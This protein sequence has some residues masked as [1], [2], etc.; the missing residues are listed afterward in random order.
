MSTSRLKPRLEMSYYGPRTCVE[1]VTPLSLLDE[2][3]HLVHGIDGFFGAVS[4]QRKALPYFLP[5]WCDVVRTGRKLENRMSY[6]LSPA[7]ARSDL[8]K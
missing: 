5:E 8:T 6:Q 3:V 4:T 2:T 1:G 7:S